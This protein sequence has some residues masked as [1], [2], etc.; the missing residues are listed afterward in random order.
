M[1]FL[2]NWLPI[3]D[4]LLYQQSLI[5]ILCWQQICAFQWL[6]FCQK[7]PQFLGGKLERFPQF[8]SYEVSNSAAFFYEYLQVFL[9]YDS[10]CFENVLTFLHF[11]EVLCI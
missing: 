2:I 5:M 8:F 6:L 3:C 4:W 1:W 11:M 10:F 7:V 9:G